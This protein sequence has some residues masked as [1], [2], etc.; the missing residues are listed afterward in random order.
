VSCGRRHRRRRCVEVDAVDFF[1]GGTDIVC[2]CFLV[3]MWDG[4][5]NWAHT[6]DNSHMT[7][8]FSIVEMNDDNT[9]GKKSTDTQ[10]NTKLCLYSFVFDLIYTVPIGLWIRIWSSP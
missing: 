2:P 5:K 10:H 4:R 9:A 6:K 1:W 7:S 8:S 3:G